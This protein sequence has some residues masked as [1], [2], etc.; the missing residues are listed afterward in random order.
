MCTGV[1]KI[2]IPQLQPSTGIGQE[3]KF[4]GTGATDWASTGSN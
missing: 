1:D 4:V 2:A 3:L